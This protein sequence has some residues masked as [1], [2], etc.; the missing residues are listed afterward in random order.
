MNSGEQIDDIKEENDLFDTSDDDV[1]RMSQYEFQEYF[2]VQ[3]E[4][5]VQECPEQEVITQSWDI[6]RPSN[7]DR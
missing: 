5:V 3:E 2:D 1:R 7:F 6:D 4:V